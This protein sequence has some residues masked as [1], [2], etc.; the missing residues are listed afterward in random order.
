MENRLAVK[1]RHQ[2][3]PCAHPAF[4]ITIERVGIRC[5]CID[6][7]EEVWLGEDELYVAAAKKL[8]EPHGR[9]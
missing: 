3:K 1:P 7:G 6:C 8:R 2:R 4:S 5:T 9:R